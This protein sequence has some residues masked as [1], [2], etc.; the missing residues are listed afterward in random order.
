MSL[1]RKRA[2]RLFAVMATCLLWE[3]GLV[4]I[5]A[6]VSDHVP[7]WR[8][9]YGM[10]F[11]G[12]NILIPAALIV[13]RRKRYKLWIKEEAENWLANRAAQSI[14]STKRWHRTFWRSLLWTPSLIALAVFLFLPEA[15]G[16]LSHAF[17]LQSHDLNGHR[18]HTPPTSLVRNY[19]NLYVSALIGRG[20]GRI[21]P[22]PYLRKEPPLSSLFFYAI[23]NPQL[24]HYRDWFL[25]SDDVRS[26]RTLSF[27]SEMMTCADVTSNLDASTS[28]LVHIECLSSNNDVSADFYGLHEDVNTFYEML[29]TSTEPPVMRIF[30][31]PPPSAPGK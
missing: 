10:M 3:V 26:R 23:V 30:R 1:L 28:T 17:D 6:F 8:D 18:L 7:N 19:N 24:D 4:Y 21:G 27:G 16:V 25:T 2:L 14:A 20:I 31:S 9:L 13:Y 22:L 12:G 29:N 5:L 11:F 15:M